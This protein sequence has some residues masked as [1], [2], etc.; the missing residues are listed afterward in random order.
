[1]ELLRL[2]GCQEDRQLKC[3]GYKVQTIQV[4]N[5]LLFSSVLHKL[6]WESHQAGRSP[7]WLF[8]KLTL[9]LVY[10]GAVMVQREWRRQ[11]AMCQMRYDD[12]R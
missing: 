7:L 6:I 2:A 10:G 4:N 8:G 9:D 5:T 3:Q 12:P 11:C 1:M